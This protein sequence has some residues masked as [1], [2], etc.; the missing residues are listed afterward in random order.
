MEIRVLLEELM[1]QIVVE[2]GTDLDLLPEEEEEEIPLGLLGTSLLQE[3]EE[4][5]KKIEIVPPLKGTLKIKKLKFSK[6][7][8]IL[9]VIIVK[10][11]FIRSILFYCLLYSHSFKTNPN[12]VTNLSKLFQLHCS[13]VAFYLYNFN[14]NSRI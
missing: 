7:C 2:Q 1:E 4:E 13:C 8:T 12:T 14:R 10:I 9:V 11:I 3:E 6:L 5:K